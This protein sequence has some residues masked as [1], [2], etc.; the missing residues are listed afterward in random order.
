MKCY[1]N[2]YWNLD[3]KKYTSLYYCL[4]FSHCILFYKSIEQKK[5]PLLQNTIIPKYIENKNKFY[6]KVLNEQKTEKV[7]VHYLNFSLSS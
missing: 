3:L 1:I 4:K 6:F 5:K 2:K 7:Q